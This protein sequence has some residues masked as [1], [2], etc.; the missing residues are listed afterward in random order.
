M[1]AAAVRPVAVGVGRRV[2]VKRRLLDLFAGA[3][4]ATRGYQDAG[5]YVVGVDIEPQPNYCGDEFHQLDA[6]LLFEYGGV[7]LTP[8]LFDLVHASPPCQENTPMNNRAKKNGWTMRWPDLIGPT[9]D[10]L[11]TFATPYVIEN[12]VGADLRRDL[13]LTGE[14]FGLKTTRARIFELG[15]W[16]AMSPPEQRRQEGSVA[17]YGK[18]DGRRLWTRV[19]GSELRAWSSLDEGREALGVPWMQTELEIREAIPPAYCEFIGR[20]FLEQHA[21]LLDDDGHSSGSSLSHMSG[22]SVSLGHRTGSLPSKGD[23]GGNGSSERSHPEAYGENDGRS[24][25]STPPQ[26]GRG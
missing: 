19:D 16:F 8:D 3:G 4:G 11:E 6:T 13:V 22:T 25:Q 24:L 1:A 18:A 9:R 14:M 2:A 5:F 23:L 10:W 17:V 12:V 21:G 15:G 26:D 7:G 20:Q